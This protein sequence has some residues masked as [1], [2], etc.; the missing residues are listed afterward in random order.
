MRIHLLSIARSVVEGFFS[1]T[2]WSGVCG[3]VVDVAVVV[4]VELVAD[5]LV[6]E[7]CWL[8][9][10]FIT[11]VLSVV[12][13]RN[14]YYLCIYY[15]YCLQFTRRRRSIFD[16]DD[17]VAFIFWYVT[18]EDWYTEQTPINELHSRG[19]HALNGTKC[20]RR[21]NW[22][23]KTTPFANKMKNNKSRSFAWFASPWHAVC[24][25]VC[26]CVCECARCTGHSL[27]HFHAHR[28]HKH[29]RL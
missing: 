4:P 24:L 2:C 22:T 28:I 9:D 29:P 19:G 17:F 13:R 23:E 20:N 25:C 12:C 1:G 14:I 15:L 6:L 10:I 7:F 5:A 3:F 11:L 21:I 18:A 16:R 26:V 8:E 27:A